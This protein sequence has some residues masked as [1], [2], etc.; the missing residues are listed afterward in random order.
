MKLRIKIAKELNSLANKDKSVVL[1]RFFKTGK[2]EYG[3]GD[4]FLGIT[5]PEQR[6]VAK[7]YFKDVDFQTIKLLLQSDIHEHRLVA[8]EMLV[9][10]YE[11]A[12]EDTIK[13]KI[14]NFYL[15]NKD[16]INNWDLVD[17]SAQYIVGDWLYDK[18]RSTLFDM[19]RSNNL[20]TRRIS[21]ISTFGFIMKGDTSTTYE[22][23]S[24]LLN[25]KHDLIQ[26]AVG[27]MLREAGKRVSEKEL[28]SFL[29]KHYKNMPRTMLRYSIERLSQKDK[30]FYMAKNKS[31]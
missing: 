9:M 4:K 15:K 11:S 31:L 1:G 8:L 6:K 24:I 27:W 23:A 28:K 5:V 10:Q 17:L 13:S 20:W 21:I 29:N 18:D 16:R 14:F 3:Y 7:K 25:D 26:K 2:G 12:K 19:A 22:I 30:L